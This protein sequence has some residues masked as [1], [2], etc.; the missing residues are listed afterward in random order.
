MVLF[1][2]NLSLADPKI[3]PTVLFF[4]K[5][6]DKVQ[7]LFIFNYIK[8]VFGRLPVDRP[9]LGHQPLEVDQPFVGR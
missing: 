3:T 6:L 7:L 4:S 1:Q 5:C 8:V 9:P 2:K